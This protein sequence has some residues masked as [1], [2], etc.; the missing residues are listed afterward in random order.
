MYTENE[1]HARGLLAILAGLVIGIILTVIIIPSPTE[2]DLRITTTQTIL[3]DGEPT[4]YTVTQD[5]LAAEGYFITH[6]EPVNY[7]IVVNGDSGSLELWVD[8]KF[9][10]T[11]DSHTNITTLNVQGRSLMFCIP[12]EYDALRTENQMVDIRET[13]AHLCPDE[14]E[15]TE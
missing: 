3:V 12:Q 9:Y 11:I 6:P 8:G 4:L 1:M 13:G 14:R 5:V 10:Q 15:S 2:A 7:S